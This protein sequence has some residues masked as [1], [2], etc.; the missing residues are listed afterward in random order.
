MPHSN[1]HYCKNFQWSKTVRGTQKKNE[2]K[3]KR[4][5][6][7]THTQK[8]KI[9]EIRNHSHI[10]YAEFQTMSNFPTEN[11]GEIGEAIVDNPGDN[12][13]QSRVTSLT[14]RISLHLLA[15]SA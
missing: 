3:R 2:G 4:E 13:K 5:V 7:E 6:R 15:P 12:W 11:G 14:E 1:Q 8:E 9:G 10:F